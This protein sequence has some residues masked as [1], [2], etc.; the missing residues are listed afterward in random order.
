LAVGSVS[1][2]I[3]LTTNCSRALLKAYRDLFVPL[4]G[5]HLNAINKGG[6]KLNEVSVKASIT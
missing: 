6:N 4:F 3:T 1:G 5:P 2:Q